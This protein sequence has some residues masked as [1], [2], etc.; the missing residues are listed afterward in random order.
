M[1]KTTTTLDVARGW[2][3][4]F[5]AIMSIL[6]EPDDEKGLLSFDTMDEVLT[7]LS[8]RYD[9][10]HITITQAPMKRL[11]NVWLPP[12]ADALGPEGEKW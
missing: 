10:Y 6:D 12:W 2:I 1:P 11:F 4:D 3:T 5:G 8:N 7:Y 9:P